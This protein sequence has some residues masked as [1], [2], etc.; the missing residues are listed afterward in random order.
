LENGNTAPWAILEFFP[1]SPLGERDAL[2]LA[3]P[4]EGE[5]PGVRGFLINPSSFKRIYYE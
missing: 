2:F 3:S 4:Q 1:L 5:G